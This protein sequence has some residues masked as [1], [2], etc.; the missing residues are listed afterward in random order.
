MAQSGEFGAKVRCATVDLQTD[1]P[2]DGIHALISLRNAF[3]KA[4]G[5]SFICFDL[6]MAD[7]WDQ[8]RGTQPR[9]DL[10]AQTAF[11]GVTSAGADELADQ[12][13][14]IAQGVLLESIGSEGLAGEIIGSLPGIGPL[15]KR[16]TNVTVRKGTEWF[17]K[18][19][20]NPLG[21]L[22]G[23]SKI[24]SA[25][26]I[27]KNLPD[28]LVHELSLRLQKLAN[29]RAGQLS[30]RHEDDALLI[31]F[32]EYENA[33]IKGGSTIQYS[34]SYDEMV[35]CVI[36]C[37]AV[38]SYEDAEKHET[39]KYSVGVLF[40]I[41]G[42][43]KIRW[44][45]ID[46][47]FT[48]FCADSQYALQGLTVNDA[49]EF[50]NQAKIFDSELQD[51][52]ITASTAFDE[53]SSNEAIYPLMLD[54]SVDIYVDLLAKNITPTP[55]HFDIKE[56]SY[57]DKRAELFRRFMRNYRDVGGLEDL[58]QRLSCLRT[59]D[60]DIV[61]YLIKQFSIPF[62]M[63]KFVSL[64]SLSFISQINGSGCFVIHPHVRE[65]LYDRADESGLLVET[66]SSIAN[67]YL[68]IG[69]PES[70][71]KLN[72]S[73]ASA[74]GLAIVNRAKCA[75]GVSDLRKERRYLVLD[76]AGYQTL[77]NPFLTEGTEIAR[78]KLQTE[79]ILLSTY[80]YALATNF[81]LMH[82]HGKA[83]ELGKEAL[84]L[85]AQIGDEAQVDVANILDRL[86]I[87]YSGITD[88]EEA[89]ELGTKALLIR[90]GVLAS[91]DPQI[92]KALHN[93]ATYHFLKSD[94]AKA[95][96]LGEEALEI[97]DGQAGNEIDKALCLG[98]LA[99]C[100][101]SQNNS[102]QAITLALKGL[103]LNEAVLPKEHP[104]IASSL[105]ILA[106]CYSISG[107]TLKAIAY[108][109]EALRIRRQVLT[110]NHVDIALS[111]NNVAR[112]YYL[113][114]KIIRAV[115]MG[116]LAIDMRRVLLGNSH[117]DTATSIHNLALYISELDIDRAIELSEEAL[118]LRSTYLGQNH[119][120]TLSSMGNL[121]SYY[122]DGRRYYKA[123]ELGE[124]YLRILNRD[125]HEA[126]LKLATVQIDLATDYGAAGD[127]ESAIRLTESA[128]STMSDESENELIL[129]AENN[130]RLF[131]RYLGDESPN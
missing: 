66:H 19:K 51:T 75:E 50:L 70:S 91:S 4:T 115:Q 77:L 117:P 120:D 46:Q 16:L 57:F 17:V 126:G 81:D 86:A 53:I 27:Y 60:R 25:E 119:R 56:K 26:E 13:K 102:E 6:A 22:Y 107:D 99:S 83:I 95:I 92:A 127:Y 29:D 24:P 21:K 59:F 52:I 114:R 32:D 43:E 89:I 1:L 84:E 7:W 111:L 34:T 30:K 78:T 94:V 76:H 106:S 85:H 64:S 35:R 18:T 48:E 61:K 45:V 103:Q 97:Y 33:M 98:N 130:L 128:L 68:N 124:A 116:Q 101:A 80:L 63:S 87:S 125:G 8:A 72:E 55:H 112:Y 42:R 109:E 44:D 79:P 3:A 39:F 36:K 15:L 131:R 129:L 47:E 118:S 88:F 96:S 73:Q 74:L 121:V 9:V 14:G 54:M 71:Q 90:K 28:V 65:T 11:K 104:E 37:C 40:L 123:I 100:Y 38:G 41:F 93:L 23:K 12:A 122:S 49:R 108:G 2:R 110:E 62:E 10:G 31:M 67:Y 20:L 82:E 113:D 105:S 58:L 5:A 69:T